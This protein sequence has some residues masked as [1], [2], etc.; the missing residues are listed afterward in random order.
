MKK[1]SM[2]VIAAL[3]LVAAATMVARGRQDAN[4]NNQAS[5]G[6]FRDGVYLARLDAR[7]G[8]AAH[9]RSGRWNN[10]RDRASFV[11]GYE[12]EYNQLFAK[13]PR[14]SVSHPADLV[15]FRD[16]ISDAAED[17]HS[18]RPFALRNAQLVR[19]SKSR[20]ANNAEY[21]A[22]YA[23]AYANGYQHGYYTSQ[24]ILQSHVIE[25][26]AKND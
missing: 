22:H 10:D 16:G 24:E 25:N 15:G 14:P 19:I 12:K 21:A 26:A 9:L 2:Y 7:L 4:S 18:E 5:D 20:S 3:V 6:A 23:Q 11:A 17:R 8:R 1:Y 13:S